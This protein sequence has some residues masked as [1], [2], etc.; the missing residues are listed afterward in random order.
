[1]YLLLEEHGIVAF[2]AL[3]QFRLGLAGEVGGGQEAAVGAPGPVIDSADFGA[4]SGFVSQFHG[5]QEI[6]Q[7]GAQGLI[8]GGEG[9][10]FGGGVEAGVADIIAD[11]GGVFLFDEAV[12]VFFIGAGS[13]EGDAGGVAPGQEGM[14]DKLRTV[15]AVDAAQGE[16]EA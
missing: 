1:V 16:G 9:L 13:G 7:E 2:I 14:V 11:A 3:C 4:H 8:D 6:V 12:V 15:N 10:V 5:G